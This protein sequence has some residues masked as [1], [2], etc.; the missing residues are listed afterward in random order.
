MNLGQFVIVLWTA[1]AAE[2][3][4]KVL[5]EFLGRD[6]SPELVALAAYSQQV[7]ARATQIASQIEQLEKE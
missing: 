2:A 5:V 6:A 7:G 1:P 4:A 3:F